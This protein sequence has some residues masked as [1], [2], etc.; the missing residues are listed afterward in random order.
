MMSQRVKRSIRQLEVF[1]KAIYILED[2]IRYSATP[3][4]LLMKKLSEDSVCG[5][6]LIFANCHKYLMQGVQ[7]QKAFHDAID[8]SRDEIYLESEDIDLILAFGN[9]LGVSDVEGQILN[10]K[11]YSKIFEGRIADLKEKTR[12]KVKL[13]ESLGLLTGIFVAIL[14]I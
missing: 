12:S 1:L 6:L 7:F 13:Y 5:K 10:T 2:E 4:V 8:A 9:G 11:R 14:L 3:V